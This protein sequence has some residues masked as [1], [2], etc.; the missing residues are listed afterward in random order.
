MSTD[1][2]LTDDAY[3]VLAGID[4]AKLSVQKR[5]LLATLAREGWCLRCWVYWAN[6]PGRQC[7]C[8]VSDDS[9]EAAAAYLLSA[10]CR[11]AKLRA[12]EAERL[13][14]TARWQA[15]TQTRPL[16]VVRNERQGNARAQPRLGVPAKDASCSTR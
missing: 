12:D 13:Y 1:Y 7:G 5:H 6:T 4:W 14:R 3:L 8:H 2:Y 15:V 16:A 11:E 9:A 10:R